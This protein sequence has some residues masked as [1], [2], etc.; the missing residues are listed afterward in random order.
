MHLALLSKGYVLLEWFKN[1]A[2]K[3]KVTCSFRI[4]FLEIVCC[5]KN[6]ELDVREEGQIVLAD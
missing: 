3:T 4:L 5:R 1:L 6:F 2:V